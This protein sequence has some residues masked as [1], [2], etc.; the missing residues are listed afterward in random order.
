MKSEE[1]V[2]EIE[3]AVRKGKILLGVSLKYSTEMKH[4]DRSSYA[5][6]EEEME[7]LRGSN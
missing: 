3:E 2:P 5:G 6:S 1:E 4:F 7:V